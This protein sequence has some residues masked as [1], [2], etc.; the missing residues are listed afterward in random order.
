MSSMPREALKPSARSR[1]DG[2]RELEAQG[3]RARH[4]F[5]RIVDVAGADLVDDFGGE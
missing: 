2:G 4:H 1:R 5:L 3:L